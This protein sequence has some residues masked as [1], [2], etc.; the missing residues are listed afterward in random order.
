MEFHFFRQEETSVDQTIDQPLPLLDADD[1]DID[2]MEWTQ[3]YTNSHHATGPAYRPIFKPEHGRIAMVS[4]DEQD[5]FVSTLLNGATPSPLLKQITLPRNP[6]IA[7]HELYE[8]DGMDMIV[9]LACQ[10]LNR[11]M[12]RWLRRL[13]YMRIPMIV[14]IY[15]PD[16][17]RNRDKKYQK[18]SHDTGVPIVLFEPEDLNKA[19]KDLL[20]ATL[21][22]APTMAVA[23]AANIDPFRPLLIDAIMDSKVKECLCDGVAVDEIQSELVNQISVAYGVGGNTLKQSQP[24]LKAMIQ[25]INDYT[26]AF[27]KRF[28]IKNPAR[29]MRFENAVS[30]MLVGYATTVYQ[31]ESSPSLRKVI[32]PKIW[33]LYRESR[34]TL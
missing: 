24:S 18:F 22:I 26:H 19:R 16:I 20:N 23:L 12:V 34:H 31:G 33:R 2:L 17:D 32:L 5:T 30:T 15:Q 4:V 6:R 13:K 28:L 14:L 8:I 25:S 9:M 27:A 21:G 10:R 7:T 3:P 11:E 29:R 1:V